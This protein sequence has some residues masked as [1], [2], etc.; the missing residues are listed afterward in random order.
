MTSQQRK[1]FGDFIRHL[2]LAASSMAL[3]SPEH[4]M[5]VDRA[6]K[7]LAVLGEAL[8]D[9][10]SATAMS[11]GFDGQILH[12]IGVAAM[13]HDVGKLMIP[14][15]ILDKPGNLDEQEWE[16]MRQHTVRGAEYL[17]NC[18]GV[19]RLAV[20]AAFEHHMKYDMSGYPKVP[21]GWQTCLCSQITMISDCFDAIRTKRVYQEAM[22]FEKAAGVML[23]LAGTGLNHDL[24]LNFLRVLRHMGEDWNPRGI[25]LKPLPSDQSAGAG[26]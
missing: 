20:M 2:V 13:L 10:G 1:L 18:P 17:L 11:L 3:Y 21:A 9:D 15:E 16:F 8:V 19:P 22:D 7:A 24:T 6:S 25:A 5:T 23:K 4:R 26:G 12:D 14:K